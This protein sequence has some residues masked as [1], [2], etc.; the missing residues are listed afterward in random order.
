MYDDGHVPNTYLYDESFD[1]FLERVHWRY[2]YKTPAAFMMD[3]TGHVVILF[4]EKPLQDFHLYTCDVEIFPDVGLITNDEKAICGVYIRRH[5]PT[6]MSLRFKLENGK[7]YDAL[8][9]I[10]NASQCTMPVSMLW[11]YITEYY[12]KDQTDPMKKLYDYC[13]AFL[14]DGIS[15]AGDIHVSLFEHVDG[16]TV[17]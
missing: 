4:D 16:I 12:G 1:N 10:I 13:E 2:V 14:E 3:D 9:Q 5:V 15:K 8:A 6:F 7:R 17:H 11:N